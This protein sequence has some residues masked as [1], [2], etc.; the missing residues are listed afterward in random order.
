MWLGILAAALTFF[1]SYLL[2]RKKELRPSDTKS[3]VIPEKPEVVQVGES[4][5]RKREGTRVGFTFPA[6]GKERPAAYL[7]CISG[8]GKGAEFAIEQAVTRLGSGKENELQV[9]DD[10][11]SGKHAAIRYDSGGLYLS[12]SG[13]RNGT[14]LNETQLRA[15]AMVLSPGDQIRVGKTTFELAA[16]KNWSRA[17]KGGLDR[18][19]TNVP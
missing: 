16:A 10:F 15:T 17:A 14:F 4:N 2:L 7:I 6:P 12:D 18:R 13:S 19:E 9:S 3:E 1:A 11:V 5:E 8:A